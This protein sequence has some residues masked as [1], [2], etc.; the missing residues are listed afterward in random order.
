MDVEPEG[1]KYERFFRPSNSAWGAFL[2]AVCLWGV[3]GICVLSVDSLW[4]MCFVCG[5]SVVCVVSQKSKDISIFPG[6]IPFQ[7]LII[8]DGKKYLI[9]RIY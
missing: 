4:G 2:S 6:T 7:I 9:R 3:C 1:A 8:I 5:Q